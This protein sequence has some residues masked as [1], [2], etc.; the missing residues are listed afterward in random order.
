MITTF[1]KTNC[2]LSLKDRPTAGK[3]R[4][5]YDLLMGRKK[6]GEYYLT[7]DFYHVNI[8]EKVCFFVSDF[9]MIRSRL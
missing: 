7:L 5:D 3:V 2:M 1:A 8:K 6:K 9:C 4:I